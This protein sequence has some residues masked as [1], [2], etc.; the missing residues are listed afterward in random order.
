MILP[1]AGA[2]VRFD[3]PYPKELH[4]LS[5]GTTVLD[6]SLAPLLDLAS[7][8]LRIRIVAVLSVCK[9]DTARYL[10]RFADRCTVVMTYQTARHGSGLR[11]ALAAAAPLCTSD[12]VLVLPDQF[13]R[14][15]PADN[16]FRAALRLLRDEDRVVL[17]APTRDPAVLRT[18]G[19]LRIELVDGVERVMAAAEK[20]AD[21]G[22]YNA[23]WVCV[24]VTAGAVAR[25]P[26]VVGADRPDLV[27]A[28]VVRVVG[29]RNVTTP[30][31]A[32]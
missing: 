10:A 19:A 20:P 22:P 28:A 31:A 15:D 6:L 21:P 17:A 14:W 11:G 9:M 8:G 23:V 29:Y 4:C 12:T 27:G 18:D 32:A 5:S 26:E 3:A 7:E 30:E 1:C 16:P 24:G 2:G 25:L 13:C